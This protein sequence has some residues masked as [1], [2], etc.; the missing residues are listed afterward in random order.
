MNYD[1][2][3]QIPEGTL[4]IS[5]GAA[6]TGITFRPAA[7]WSVRDQCFYDPGPEGRTE[8]LVEPVKPQDGGIQ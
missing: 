7:G 3:I 6:Q 5:R 2:T 8:T 1:E 4:T